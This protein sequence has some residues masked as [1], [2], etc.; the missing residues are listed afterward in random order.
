[1]VNKANYSSLIGAIRGNSDSSLTNPYLQ[2]R[3]VSHISS[4]TRQID[5]NIDKMLMPDFDFRYSTQVKQKV[6]NWEPDYQ[7]FISN[8][9]SVDIG[10]NSK[11][12]SIKIETKCPKKSTV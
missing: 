7:K 10:D 12:F 3:P 2:L 5:F 9:F 4:S 6:G 8:S 1:M 11:S